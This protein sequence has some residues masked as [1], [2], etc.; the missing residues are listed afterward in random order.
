MVPTTNLFACLAFF[1]IASVAQGVVLSSPEPEMDPMVPLPA[2]YVVSAGADSMR[3]PMLTDGSKIC[4]DDY[5]HGFS[6]QCDAPDS[7]EAAKFFVNGE[8]IKSEY[9]LP[10]YIAGDYKM[11][12]KEWT[13]YP[14]QG[15][16]KCKLR[17]GS[18][19]S[20]MVSFS[21]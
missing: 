15:M 17:D 2:L 11:R 18:S 21:C 6:I 20:A 10:F 19:A 12:V 5:P 9:H 16:L 3:G 8:F 14:N 7:A 13:H 1:A 4:P